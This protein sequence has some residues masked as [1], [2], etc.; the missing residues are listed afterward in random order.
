MDVLLS[1][2]FNKH[3][4]NRI[5]LSV[6]T[7]MQGIYTYGKYP[8]QI[9]FRRYTALQLFRIYSIQHMKCDFSYWTFCTFT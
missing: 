7:I 8:K 4:L 5:E 2:N 1:I 9:M 6:I 3:P